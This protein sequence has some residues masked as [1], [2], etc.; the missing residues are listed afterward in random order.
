MKLALSTSICGRLRWYSAANFC[1]RKPESKDTLMI[2]QHLF[3]LPGF[4]LWWSELSPSSWTCNLR[5]WASGGSAPPP[6]EASSMESSWRS[7]SAAWWPPWS[8]HCTATQ[9]WIW[10]RG[11][12]L[13]S[14]RRSRPWRAVDRTKG[15]RGEHPSST[16]QIGGKLALPPEFPA[17][18]KQEFPMH[19]WWWNALKIDYSVYW[20]YLPA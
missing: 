4:C 9:I 1:K 15:R 17:L 16:C 20:V 6:A 11:C 14:L 5:N 13:W 19:N 12:W 2:Y 7:T 10:H 8:L 3:S 18:E